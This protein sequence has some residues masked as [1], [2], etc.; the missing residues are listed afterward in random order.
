MFPFQKKS[1]AT[2]S[3]FRNT[4]SR[5]DLKFRL[6]VRAIHCQHR[7]TVR[8]TNPWMPSYYVISRNYSRTHTLNS[9]PKCISSA[10][11]DGHLETNHNEGKTVLPTRNILA[12]GRVS[13]Y[14]FCKGNFAMFINYWTLFGSE[15]MVIPYL[16]NTIRM[17][18]VKGHIVV[19]CWSL[20]TIARMGLC[21]Y[22]RARCCYTSEY[23]L[24][25]E[26]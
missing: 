22:R 5:R 19:K 4:L 15:L 26:R 6:C 16:N 18:I 24:P 21:T 13:K 2:Y 23:R 9:T 1:S 8:I 17:P 14:L 12:G 3:H 10:I 7:N 20:G 11:C 25:C